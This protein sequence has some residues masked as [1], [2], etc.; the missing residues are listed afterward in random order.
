MGQK[1]AKYTLAACSGLSV[2]PARNHN[3]YLDSSRTLSPTSAGLF[4]LFVPRPMSRSP[5][6]TS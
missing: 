2:C 1:A 4:Y 3:H 5:S 6:N